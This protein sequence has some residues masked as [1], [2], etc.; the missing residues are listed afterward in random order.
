MRE[1]PDS[2]LFVDLSLVQIVEQ[3]LQIG[4]TPATSLSIGI[5]TPLERHIDLLIILNIGDG[6]D[7]CR[8]ADVGN[9]SETIREIIEGITWSLRIEQ[10]IAEV[11]IL[12]MNSQLTQ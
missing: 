9:Q 10:I 12:M 4:L 2:V 1:R 11:E 6:P 7:T 8:I 5:I 3:A